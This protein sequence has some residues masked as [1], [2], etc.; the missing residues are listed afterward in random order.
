[1]EQT[2]SW[3]IAGASPRHVIRDDKGAR[4]ALR[5]RKSGQTLLF[6]AAALVFSGGITAAPPRGDNAA[7]AAGIA[8][9][10]RTASSAT[11]SIASRP[12]ATSVFGCPLF[13]I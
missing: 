4:P 10:S 6:D 12:H 2:E 13:G 5:R 7:A 3:R 1:M 8:D 9:Q 11:A